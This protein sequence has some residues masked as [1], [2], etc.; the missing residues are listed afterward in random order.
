MLKRNSHNTQFHVNPVTIDF[1]RGQL[2][3]R[4]TPTFNSIINSKKIRSREIIATITVSFFYL[5]CEAPHN[6]IKTQCFIFAQFDL[7]G[8]LHFS[9]VR[10]E[11]AILYF[12]IH[13]G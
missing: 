13:K 2:F 12:V 11:F 7:E 9:E 6:L 10:L 8:A 3:L 1:G 5:R 4:V